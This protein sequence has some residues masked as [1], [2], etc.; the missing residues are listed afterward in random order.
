MS[1]GAGNESAQDAAEPALVPAYSFPAWQRFTTLWMS[2]DQGQGLRASGG[3]QIGSR[4]V[5]GQVR[6]VR[7]GV[8]GR[9]NETNSPQS[10]RP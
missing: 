6:F 4:G 1:E 3:R 10:L 8:W 9:L 7:W 5:N 2:E